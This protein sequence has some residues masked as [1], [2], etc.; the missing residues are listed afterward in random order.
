MAIAHELADWS[1]QMLQ[2]IDASANPSIHDH[3]LHLRVQA[4]FAEMPGLKLT[5]SQASRLFNLERTLCE[6]VLETL[7]DKRVLSHNGTMFARAGSN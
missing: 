7:V 1:R 5:L 6:R 2:S 3:E 4:E